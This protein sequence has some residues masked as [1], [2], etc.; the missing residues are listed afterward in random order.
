M[1]TSRDRIFATLRAGLKDTV[2][3]P[4]RRA[5]ERNRFSAKRIHG[6]RGERARTLF[7]GG[8]ER[9][10]LARARFG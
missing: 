8:K 2:N 5:G 6:H 9:I 4:G 10:Q 7:A 3:D 1:S